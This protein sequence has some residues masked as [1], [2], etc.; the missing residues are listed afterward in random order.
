MGYA[1]DSEISE[2]VVMW[3]FWDKLSTDVIKLEL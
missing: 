1:D 2:A 3:A